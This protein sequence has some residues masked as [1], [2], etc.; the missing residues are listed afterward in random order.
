MVPSCLRYCRE[1]L[2]SRRA[3]NRVCTRVLDR[4]RGGIRGVCDVWETRG[5]MS[6]PL[7]E[8]PDCSDTENVGRSQGR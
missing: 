7:D 1:P 3:T 2:S 6:N 4:Y 8:I 5:I